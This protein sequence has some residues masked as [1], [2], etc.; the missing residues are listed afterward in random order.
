MFVYQQD[1]PTK[2]FL[3]LNGEYMFNVTSGGGVP[4]LSTMALMPSC[5]PYVTS[6][7]NYNEVPVTGFT[8]TWTGTSCHGDVRLLVLYASGVYAGVDITTANDGSYTFTR[9]DLSLIPN[10]VSLYQLVL[11]SENF[12]NID[13]SGYDPR[14]YAGGRTLNKTYI[15]FSEP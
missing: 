13:A 3:V 7:R 15:Y 1:T 8:A 14:S 6:P 11:I 9:Q 5:R 4:S 10:L 2:A 12:R